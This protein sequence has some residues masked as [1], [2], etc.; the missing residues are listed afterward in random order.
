MRLDGVRGAER[1]LLFRLAA[2][3]LGATLLVGLSVGTLWWRDRYGAL[4]AKHARAEEA[5]RRRDRLAAMGE[6][7]ASVAH[8]VRNPLNAIAMSVKRVRREFLGAPAESDA[9]RAELSELLGVMEAETQ[10][11]NRTVQQF[12]D[13]A[14]PP[15]L[16]PQPTDLAAF[17]SGLVESRRPLAESRGVTL[18]ADVTGAG[19]AMTDPDQLRQAADNVLRNAIEATPAGGRVSVRARSADR[20]H[21]IEVIDDGEGIASDKLGRIF[22]L[23][24]TTKPEGTGVGLAVTQQIVA[25]HGGAVDVESRP[26]AGTR[27][28]LRWPRALPEARNG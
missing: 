21:A 22:D 12:L 23:Y 25:A 17:A 3:L 4:S 10:R 9:D 5:L 18:D 1:R 11:I 24:Y 14:R 20:E 19:E 2:S 8:E 7:A 26:G 6:L 27:V 28:T 16:D 15:R 13:F